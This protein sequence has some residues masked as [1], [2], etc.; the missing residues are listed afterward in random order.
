MK[1]AL[2]AAIVALVVLLIGLQFA[3][4]YVVKT[5]NVALVVNH[6]TG[7]IDTRIRHAGFNFVMPGSGNEL[8][9]IPT[10]ARTYTMVRDSSEGA[11]S[12]DDSVLVNTL[13]DR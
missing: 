12:G 9:E 2:Y 1:K 5:G 8:I 13:S 11:N 3:H 6:Y 4:G 7:R 10:Y